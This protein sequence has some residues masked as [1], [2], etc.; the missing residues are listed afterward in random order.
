MSKGRGRGAMS[1]DEWVAQHRCQGHH[2]HPAPTNENRE[3][4][5]CKCDPEAVWTAVWRILT[6][7]QVRQKF[8]HLSKRRTPARDAQ[9]REL[10][11]H[12]AEIQAE[13]EKRN[14]ALHKIDHSHIPPLRIADRYAGGR[15]RRL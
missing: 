7:E 1:C 5:E 15:P 10:R 14:A 3:R 8:A 11:A 13:Q 2:P 12:I 4:W 9:R 6:P